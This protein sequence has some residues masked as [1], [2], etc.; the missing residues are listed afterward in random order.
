MRRLSRHRLRRTVLTARKGL[1]GC[2]SG[3]ATRKLLSWTVATANEIA[4]LDP[5]VAAARAVGENP[6][7]VGRQCAGTAALTRKT[8]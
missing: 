8:L 3:R 5:A 7:F 6:S 4:G 1:S 2:M